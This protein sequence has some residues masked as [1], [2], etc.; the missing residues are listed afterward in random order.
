[1]RSIAI[2]VLALPLTA[3]APGSDWYRICRN[4]ASRAT[5]YMDLHSIESIGARAQ[6]DELV[7]F[8]TENGVTRAIRVHIE[9]DC[10]AHTYRPL[11]ETHLDSSGDEIG[12]VRAEDFGFQPAEKNRISGRMLAFACDPESSEVTAV[13]DPLHDEHAEDAP[14]AD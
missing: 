11:T 8:D 3:A 4:P 1:M 13:E 5:I 2:A 6:A 9:F 14:A 12:T 10:D 7:V